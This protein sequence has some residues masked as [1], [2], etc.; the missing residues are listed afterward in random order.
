MSHVNVPTLVRYTYYQLLLL[1]LLQHNMLG[2]AQSYCPKLA[3]LALITVKQW[4]S[5]KSNWHMTTTH[6]PRL[7]GSILQAGA[8]DPKGQGA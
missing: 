3:P 8:S 1:L 2:N 7:Y 6:L 5:N 4:R